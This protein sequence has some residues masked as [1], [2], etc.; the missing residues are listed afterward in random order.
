[1]SATAPK[2]EALEAI[3]KEIEDLLTKLEKL[4]RS[5]PNGTGDGRRVYRSRTKDDLKRQSPTEK[6]DDGYRK[7]QQYLQDKLDELK[8]H[9]REAK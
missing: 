5:R 9:A 6:A 8:K 4:D 7:M 1:M 3:A 2:Q